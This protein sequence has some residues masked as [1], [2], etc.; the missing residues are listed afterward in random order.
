MS[1][2]SRRPRRGT[3]TPRR[4][5]DDGSITAFTAIL[6]VALVAA[7]GLVLDAGNARSAR[8]HAL[9]QAQAAARIGAQAIDLTTYRTGGAQRLDP[10]AA[11]TAAQTWLNRH[12]LNGSVH[13][14]PTAVTA[15]VRTTTRTQLLTLVG[16]DH[17][18]VT[19]T[20]TA[21]ARHVTS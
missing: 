1:A 21:T 2:A 17:L 9:D 16:V 19:A 12:H 18:D 7:A 15:T 20:A 6:I 13:A 10:A 4:P 14:T 3:R 11:E 8:F 5:Y